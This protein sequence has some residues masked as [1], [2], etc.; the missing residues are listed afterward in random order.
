MDQLPETEN[1][2]VL[3]TDFSDDAVWEAI[4]DAIQ[5]PV[6]G[7]Q[8]AVDCV[9]DRRVEGVTAEQLPSL[10][11]D[12]SDHCVVFVVDQRTVAD[13][14]RAVLVVDVLD[15]PG[16]SFRVI[17]AAMWSVENNLAIANMDFEEFVDAIDED[18]VFR[19]FQELA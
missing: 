9:S 13:P 15:E 8:A 11:G 19:G 5:K 4:C 12:D 16:R 18:G 1:S 6:G 10:I 17:P 3:R 7:F 14:E 2:L